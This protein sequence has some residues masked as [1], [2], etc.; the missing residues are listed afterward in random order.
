MKIFL[1]WLKNTFMQ[2]NKKLT[3]WDSKNIYKKG[4]WLTCNYKAKAA[5]ASNLQYNKLHNS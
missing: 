5:S 3:V 1:F 2:I 4:S